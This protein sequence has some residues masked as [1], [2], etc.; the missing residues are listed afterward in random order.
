MRACSRAMMAVVLTAGLAGAAGGAAAQ[1]W[2]NRTITVVVAYAPGG[3][4]DVVARIIAAKLQTALGQNVVVEN[5]AGA[6]GAIGAQSVIRAAPDGHTILLGQTGEIA[7]NQH[8]MKNPGYDPD[9]D[10]LPV[11]L[12]T[13]VPLALCIPPN[14]SYKT[15]DELLKTANATPKGLTF[16]SAG[17]G[18]PGH[19]AGELLKLR[20]K[21]NLT[22]VPYKGAGPALN[23]ILGG[24]VDLYFSGYPAAM[25]HQKSGNVKVLAVSSGRRSANAPDVPTVAELTGIKEFDLTLW[26]GFFVPRG[27]PE[28]IVVRL[29]KEINDILAQPDVRQKLLEAGADIRPM[30]IPEFTAF[31]K[32]QSDKYQQIIKATGVTID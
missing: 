2:P 24:H 9:K 21:T 8:L 10:L 29:N 31:V 30:S 23:D 12:G 4:G 14:A 32:E 25:P 7:I 27:T 1:T 5:R 13:D 18:T 20:T 16:A 17:T 15:L 6:T 22:H 3:T 19:F 26:Q 11:A 28:D